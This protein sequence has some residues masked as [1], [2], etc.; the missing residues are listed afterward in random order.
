MCAALVSA[1][2]AITAR[3]SHSRERAPASSHHR[4]AARQCRR[5]T[6]HARLRCEL[7]EHGGTSS[8]AQPPC[9]A[10]FAGRARLRSG[11]GRFIPD[12]SRAVVE[13]CARTLP[14][15]L[16]R[17]FTTVYVPIGLGSRH[18]RPDPPRADA[19][20]GLDTQIVGSSKEN[21]RMPMPP[22]EGGPRSLLT[23]TS[24]TFARAHATRSGCLFANHQ[25]A[26]AGAHR[27][28]VSDPEVAEGR[29]GSIT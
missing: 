23:E 5:R 28:R 20:L 3:A 6:R 25:E 27:M 18:L 26:G 1:S 22:H 16:P 21:G 8:R 24:R 11:P 19:G 2:A 9:P 10:A 29:S 14:T 17:P 12:S 4:R 7:I 13:L 15:A